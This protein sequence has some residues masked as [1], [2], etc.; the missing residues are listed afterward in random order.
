MNKKV[1]EY[2]KWNIE[3]N[4]VIDKRKLYYKCINNIKLCKNMSYSSFVG[5]LRGMEKIETDEKIVK[6]VGE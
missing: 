6:Y 2:I 5:I 3:R 1:R 4:K